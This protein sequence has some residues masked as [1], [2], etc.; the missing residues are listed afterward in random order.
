MYKSL[1]NKEET[2]CRS[3]KEKSMEKHEKYGK[4]KT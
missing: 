4:S 1:D 2:T 3:T